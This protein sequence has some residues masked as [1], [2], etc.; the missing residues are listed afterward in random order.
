MTLYVQYTVIIGVGI[1]SLLMIF[2]A[3]LHLT[4]HKQ[5]KKDKYNTVNGV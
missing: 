1:R 4:M 5:P 2:K 3:F